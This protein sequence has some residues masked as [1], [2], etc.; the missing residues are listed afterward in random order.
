MNKLLVKSTIT[1]FML[2]FWNLSVELHLA[3][4]LINQ[5]GFMKKQKIL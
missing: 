1:Q 5:E 3:F 2:S 4:I